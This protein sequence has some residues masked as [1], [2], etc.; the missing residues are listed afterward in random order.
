V[1][2]RKQPPMHSLAIL[3]GKGGS[4]KTT[5]AISLAAAF[6]ERGR[7]VLVCDF[8][9]V[10]GLTYAA[11][12]TAVGAGLLEVLEGRGEPDRVARAS[13][14]GFSVLAGSVGL[15]RPKTAL[16]PR[17][18]LRSSA[19]LIIMDAPPGFGALPARIVG[20]AD[21]VLVPIVAEPLAVRTV[22]FVLGMVDAAQPPPKMLGVLPTMY[23]PRRVLTTDQTAA[24]GALGVPV[25]APIPRSVAVAEASLA[26]VSVLHYAPKN[27]AAVAYR[28]LARLLSNGETS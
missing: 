26:G 1:L 24:L 3:S 6:T 19:D 27:P 2:R 7:R 17:R 15:E 28:E 4:G 23:E 16:D 8:D 11:G 12:L 9:P 14:E 13:S 25:L 10:G 22:E 5:T 18:L 20:F 21:A